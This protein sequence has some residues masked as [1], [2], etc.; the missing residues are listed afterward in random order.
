M[1]ELY[2]AA[3]RSRRN[4]ENTNLHHYR[5][6]L[7]YIVIDRQCNELNERFTEATTELLVCVAC[8]SPVDSFSAFDKQ[9][10]IRLA[11]FYPN[12]FSLMECFALGDDLDAY[13]HDMRNSNEFSSLRSLGEL[14]QN[15]VS[16]KRSGVYPSIYRLLKLALLLPVA[17]ATVE[18][19]FSA[20]KIIKNRMRNRMGDQLLHDSLVVYIERNKLNEISNETIIQRFQ[21]MK[22]RRKQL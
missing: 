16:H 5:V 17:T 21:K 2:L 4:N 10:L 1:E 8:L 13:I 3:G 12:D 22:T 15:L 11:S 20:M 18:S 19:A 14:A 9:K 6:E 7:F